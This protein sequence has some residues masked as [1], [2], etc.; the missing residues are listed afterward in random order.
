MKVLLGI[1]IET[2]VPD[3]SVAGNG[4]VCCAAEQKSSDL[5]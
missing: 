2:F 1:L 5:G 3:E 4:P